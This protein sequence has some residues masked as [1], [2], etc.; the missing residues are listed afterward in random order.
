MLKYIYPVC[1]NDL[2]ESE[3][4]D[5]T[6]VFHCINCGYTYIRKV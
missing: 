4:L 1:G 2:E 5:N 3:G 6:D